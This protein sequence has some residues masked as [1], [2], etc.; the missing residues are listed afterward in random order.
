[1]LLGNVRKP[2]T[3]QKTQALSSLFRRHTEK[4]DVVVTMAC[5]ITSSRV[6]ECV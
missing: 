3:K 1:M 6:I 2:Q 4:A 5:N